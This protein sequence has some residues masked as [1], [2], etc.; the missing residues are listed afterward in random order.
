[1]P[2]SCIV[3]CNAMRAL[4]L[5]CCRAMC[6]EARLP[7]QRLLLVL[8]TYCPQQLWCRERAHLLL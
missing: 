2:A 8:P 4:W 7:R 3:R 1:M 6:S 5:H